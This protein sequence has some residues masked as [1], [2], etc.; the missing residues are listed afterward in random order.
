[1]GHLGGWLIVVG[2]SLVVFGFLLLLL[3]IPY[4]GSFTRFSV[5]TE[6]Y[7]SR[8]ALWCAGAGLLIL[9]LVACGIV[10]RKLIVVWRG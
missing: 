8:A 10:A 1:M 6:F 3:L 4:F 5:K 2:L 9:V 7:S